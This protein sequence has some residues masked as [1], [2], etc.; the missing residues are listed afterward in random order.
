MELLEDKL[1]KDRQI[2]VYGTVD[3]VND[4]LNIEEPLELS[5]GNSKIILQ[6]PVILKMKFMT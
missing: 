6:V 5:I 2:S 4:F 1:Y 3:Y